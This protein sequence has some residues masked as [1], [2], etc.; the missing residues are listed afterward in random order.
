M[1]LLL[2]SSAGGGITANLSA[3][4]GADTLVS[5]SVL[6]IQASASL[7]EGADTIVSAS[8]LAIQASASLTEGADT[9]VSAAVIAIAIAASADLTEDAD[10]LVS[11]A[12]FVV[13]QID[14]G[15]GAFYGLRESVRKRG[16]KRIAD[17]LAA[18]QSAQQ[19]ILAAEQALVEPE[20]VARVEPEPVAR[21]EPEPVARELTQEAVA[22]LRDGGAEVALFPEEPATVLEEARQQ[23]IKRNNAAI[24]AL[25]MA[26]AA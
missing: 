3:T 21:V 8:V 6:A 24:I 12:D 4:E 14:G 15:G 19:A 2:R 20:P 1:L 26:E 18:Q 5:A 25:F 17:D 7:T 22:A 9:L 16:R 23:R 13:A 11:T 10:T